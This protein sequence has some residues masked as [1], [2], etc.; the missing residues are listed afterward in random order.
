MVEHLEEIAGLRIVDCVVEGR[1]DIKDAQRAA[2][3]G[4]ADDALGGAR[5]RSRDHQDHKADQTKDG[6]QQVGQA[7]GQF[8]CVA[9]VDQMGLLRHG[10]VSLTWGPAAIIAKFYK[11]RLFG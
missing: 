9:V 1:D 4:R 3:D 8:L 11:V 5:A 6:G 2:E 10:S 7:F